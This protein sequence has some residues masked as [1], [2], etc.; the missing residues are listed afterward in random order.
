M[1][2]IK[3]QTTVVSAFY[4]MP[5]K[6][7]VSKYLAWMRQFWPATDCALVFFTDS[8]SAPAV[9]E[10]LATRPKERTL[11]I[12]QPFEELTGWSQWPGKA[13]WE[14]AEE[15]DTEMSVGHS[16]ELY[17]IWYEKK[18][19]VRR[20]IKANPFKSEWFVW[21]D[22]GVGR[23]D[24]WATPGWPMAERIPRGRMLLLQIG[25]FQQ[26]DWVQAGAKE[27]A[28]G[29]FGSRCTVGG[30]ILA[31]DAA[32]WKRWSDAY[33][34]MLRRYLERGWFVG[35]DQNIMASAVLADPTLA[36]LIR[37]PSSL[38]TVG[39]WFYFLLF[40]AGKSAV[41]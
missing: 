34:A 3:A 17:S 36:V 5:S 12:V 7:S 29:E 10:V 6:F 38:G 26:E 41:F 22:A 30:G 37:A 33:D 31:S 27:G 28:R 2:L 24:G 1:E 4:L 19:F 20:V 13:V 9:A 35:K 39:M 8:A 16:P 40:L 11:L 25:A 18:E 14:S 32:G 15:L 23:G 21:C